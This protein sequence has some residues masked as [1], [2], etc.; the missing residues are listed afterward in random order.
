[1]RA[2]QVEECQGLQEAIGNVNEKHKELMS[3]MERKQKLMG[4]VSELREI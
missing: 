3:T 4:E 2:V 1:M